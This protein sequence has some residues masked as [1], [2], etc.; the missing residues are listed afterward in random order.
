MIIII[1]KK[2]AKS[3]DNLIALAYVISIVCYSASYVSVLVVP[4]IFPG[5]MMMTG[6]EQYTDYGSSNVYI[7]VP[8]T[9]LGH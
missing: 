8:N 2:V 7:T 5:T 9:K 3:S 1:L 4:I 6:S